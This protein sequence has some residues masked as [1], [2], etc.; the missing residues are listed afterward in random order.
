VQAARYRLRFTVDV[1]LPG[2]EYGSS[3]YGQMTY[4]QSV[5]DPVSASRYVALPWP[6]GYLSSPAWIYRRWDTRPDFE[7]MVID[8]EGNP[9][10]FT[11]TL[12]SLVL[13]PYDVE[14]DT[15]HEFGMNEIA[16][17]GRVRRKWAENDLN[18]CGLYRAVLAFY[19]YP[20][21]R[22]LTVPFDDRCT[23]YVTD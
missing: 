12:I 20:S 23:F 9:L 18:F 1:S 17:P 14:D 5:T 6:G 22:R 16:P 3:D 2:A 4:G 21:G 19:Y 11:S 15:W 13:S 7:A 10:D 8:P